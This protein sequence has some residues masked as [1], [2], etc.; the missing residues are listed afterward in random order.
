MPT[1]QYACRAC[2][3]RFETT[4]GFSEDALTTCPQCD[5]VA[6]RK[7]FGNVGVVFKGSG[8]YR[9]DSRAAA[10]SGGSSQAKKSEPASSPGSPAAAPTGSPAASAKTSAD[11]ATKSPANA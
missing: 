5:Q 8:F 3:H 1:Y 2:E 9:N 7:L 4:Q 11:T 10:K 6:L